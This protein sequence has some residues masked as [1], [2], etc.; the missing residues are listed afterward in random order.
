MAEAGTFL[1]TTTHHFQIG[2][3]SPKAYQMCIV[4][5]FPMGKVV[6]AWNCPLTPIWCQG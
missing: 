1:F 6:G 2:S 4:D 5:S 3:G